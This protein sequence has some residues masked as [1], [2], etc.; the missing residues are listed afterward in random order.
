MFLVASPRRKRRRKSKKGKKGKAKKSQKAIE[1]QKKK[2]IEKELTRFRQEKEEKC[3]KEVSLAVCGDKFDLD[4]FY[5]A[6]DEDFC[7]DDQI[8]DN[9]PR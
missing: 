4:H 3:I 7:Y 6:D 2:A 5:N 9:K 8:P 1:R